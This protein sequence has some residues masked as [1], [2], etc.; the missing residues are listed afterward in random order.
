MCIN[1]GS[2]SAIATTMLEL[3]VGF[4]SAYLLPLF[5]F[6]VGFAVLIKG[7]KSYIIKPP[8]G[9]VIGNC[10]RALYIAS[11]NNFN[12]DAA[13]PSFQ[14]GPRKH[15][16]TWEDKFIDELKTALDACKVFLFFPIYW[17][18]FSQMMNNFVSQGRHAI[19]IKRNV[20]NAVTQLVK[21]N[22]TASQTTYSQTSIPSPSSL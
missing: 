2:V 21:C 3:H 7:K 8:Q 18:T 17:L 13:K 1:V 9:G 15:K 10:F 19:S 22:S 11:R 14:Q 12:L 4:W 6:S 16:I 5:M 20:A